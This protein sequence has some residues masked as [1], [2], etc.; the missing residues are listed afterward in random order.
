MLD[1]KGKNLLG[2]VFLFGLFLHFLLGLIPLANEARLI[3]QEFPLLWGKSNEER[4]TAILGG[5]LDSVEDHEFIAR[6]NSEI[7]ADADVLIITNSMANVY[8]LNYYLYP[9]R[10]GVEEKNLGQDHWTVHYF[11]PK[12]LGLNNIERPQ[13]NGAP[14]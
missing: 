13:D 7:P 11:S 3:L 5:V 12:A 2:K 6:C 10:T 8:T 1:T 4:R 14:D 9:R